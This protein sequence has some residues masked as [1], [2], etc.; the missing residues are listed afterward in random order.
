M[1]PS[2]W[3][4][5]LPVAPAGIARA[6]NVNVTF[7]FSEAANASGAPTVADWLIAY[8]TIGLALITLVTLVATVMITRADRNIESKRL[9]E[10]RQRGAQDRD[11][12]DRRLREERDAA[13]QRLREERE[14]R[15]EPELLKHCADFSAACGRIKRE[16]ALKKPT[17]R[18][19]SCIPQMEAAC[20]AL[21]V[22]GTPEIETAADRFVGIFQ[23]T[24][25]SEASANRSEHEKCLSELFVAHMQ[26]IA[27]VRKHFD[28]P[29]KV[30]VAV[31]MIQIP[32]QQ[33]RHPRAKRAAQEKGSDE[34]R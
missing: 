11:D 16:L 10:E 2:R 25:M 34:P 30:Y 21:A 5:F 33:Q 6:R 13:D 32:D 22:I 29:P 4:R 20:D 24:L 26:F 15:S 23:A 31:P 9:A 19:F 12:A 27:A 28:R 18:D 7:T 1:A 14:R 8:G 3:P 17:N